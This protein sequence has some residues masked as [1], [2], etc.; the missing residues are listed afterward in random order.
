[1]S[2]TDMSITVT[3][4]LLGSSSVTVYLTSICEALGTERD[5]QKWEKRWRLHTTARLILSPTVLVQ[6][7]N[8]KHRALSL[9]ATQN[10]I[11]QM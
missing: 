8:T 9:S 6:H 2:H 5:E 11:G 4:A 3:A 7:P 10:M 1:M